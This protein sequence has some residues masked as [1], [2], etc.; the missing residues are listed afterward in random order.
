MPS[1]CIFDSAK[2][3]SGEVWGALFGSPLHKEEKGR[4]HGSRHTM[5]PW[6]SGV[7]SDA[8][9]GIS[10]HRCVIV[11]KHAATKLRRWCQESG[12]DIFPTS[13]SDSPHGS[14]Q[15]AHWIRCLLIVVLIQWAQCLP[16]Q[17]QVTNRIVALHSL[18]EVGILGQLDPLSNKLS[19]KMM[20]AARGWYQVIKLVRR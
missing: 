10:S 3:L 5:T 14:C 6:R 13:P 7:K 9:F 15:G 4:L 19:Y 17:L 18:V 2:R 8:D 11:T 20:R 12:L 1:A 16:S